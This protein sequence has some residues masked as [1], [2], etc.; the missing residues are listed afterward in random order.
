MSVLSNHKHE[1][2]SQ[3]LAK[4]V[5]AADAYV[6]AGYSKI[7]A[8]VSA[9]RLRAHAN[10]RARVCE[11]QEALAVGTIELE[12]SSRNARVHALQDR[13]TTLRAGIALLLAERGTAMAG[14][15]GGSSGLLMVDYKGKELMPVYRRSRLG[16]APVRSARPRAA[17]RHGIR[18]ME[19]PNRH[20][21]HG[22]RNPDGGRFEPVLHLHA[23]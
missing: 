10:I 18:A 23:A 3:L 13:W 17:G 6:S 9:S 7:G 8:K 14:T 20:R 2:F 22:R 15:S 19:D 4:G 16:V 11:L 1:H 12:I 5:S 21:G